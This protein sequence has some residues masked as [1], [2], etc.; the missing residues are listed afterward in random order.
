LTPRFRLF[1]KKNEP[2]KANT[3]SNQLQTSENV[4]ISEALAL[5]RTIESRRNEELCGDL[6]SVRDAVAKS[7]ITIEKLANDLEREKIKV[8]E[9]KFESIVEISKRTVV[10]SLRRESSMEL[11][12]PNSYND[13]IKFKQRLEAITNRFREVSASHN[14]VFNVFIKK[15]AGKLKDEFETLSS[16]SK[17]MNSIFVKFDNQQGPF[18]KCSDLLNQ[19]SD[20]ISSIEQDKK[21]VDHTRNEIMQLQMGLG[22]LNNRMT[23]MENSP[24]FHEAAKIGEEIKRL[25]H[26]EEEAHKELLDLFSPVSRAFT[27]YSYG[28]SKQTSE[29]LRVLTEEPWNIFS[30]TELTPYLD[31]LGDIQKA[32]IT[33]KI[34]LKDTMKVAGQLKSL[35]TV[36]RDFGKKFEIRQHYLKTLRQRNTHF[37]SRSTDLKE[38]IHNSAQR[39]EEEEIKLHQLENQ[40]EEKRLQLY[41]LRK[42]SEDCLFKIFDKKY[43]LAV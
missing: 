7:L 32:L 37:G 20:K 21:G 43:E 42:E 27:K 40:L 33:E 26:E 16:L 5:I 34:C 1:N 30:E 31:I 39:I 38:E 13:A 29:R 28:L 25:E 36:L 3:G 14:R 6:A 41:E 9:P 12:L 17:K 22:E 23:S 35:I 2:S 18:L 15:Y 24:E 11:P 10:A 8:E 19:L 4:L